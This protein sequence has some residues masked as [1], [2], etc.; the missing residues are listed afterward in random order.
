MSPMRG[1]WHVVPCAFLA[2]MVF[3]VPGVLA[4]QASGNFLV[5]VN[6]LKGATPSSGLCRSS[7]LPGA[8]GATATVVCATGAVVDLEPGRLGQPWIPTHGGA[9][10]YVTQVN[11]GAGPLGIIDVYSGI[12]TVTAW[13]V[14]SMAEREYLEMTVG[15]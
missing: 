6:L 14:I 2:L 7:S 8:F 10:R 1:V 11:S 13:R 9:Y 3:V 5:T 12:G 4:G 15:W